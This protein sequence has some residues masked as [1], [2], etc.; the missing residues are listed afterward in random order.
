[1]QQP[2]LLL[3][4]GAKAAFAQFLLPAYVLVAAPLWLINGWD[5]VV[6]LVTSFAGLLFITAFITYMGDR[7][8]PWSAPPNDQTKGG[9]VFKNIL[10]ML[11]LGIT[12]VIHGVLFAYP[13]ALWAL[14]LIAGISS[15]AL[16]KSISKFD[17][18][19][20]K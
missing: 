18:L 3:S 2:G 14:A 17:W 20:V 4:G 19:D 12:G 16:F 13:L 5:I 15:F 10:L 6:H 7:Y 9:T 8:L 1:L 11:G